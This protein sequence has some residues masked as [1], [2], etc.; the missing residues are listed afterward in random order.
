MRRWLLVCIALAVL[1][2]GWRPAPKEPEGLALVRVLGVDGPGPV[3]LTA[4]CGGEDQEGDQSR[5][6]CAGADF[7]EA[8]AVLPWSGKEELSLTS[9]S[10]II[11]GRDEEL[12]AAA[13]VWLAENGA[14]ELLGGCDDPAS[15]LELIERQGVEA[16]TVVKALAALYDGGGLCLP[17]LTAGEDG[18]MLADWEEWR[19]VYA[20]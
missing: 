9:V 7:G 3:T 11:V 1:L 4:V 5:G 8:L 2:A 12:G 17:L 18:L 14:A 13:T 15:A 16:P 6:K 10:Y 19:G 20:Q